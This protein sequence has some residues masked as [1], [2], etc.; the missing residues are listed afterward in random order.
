MKKLFTLIELLVVIAI[1]AILASMLLP[2]LNKARE[3]AKTIKCAGNMKSLSTMWLM[4]M[5]NNNDNLLSYD[6]DTIRNPNAGS[7]TSNDG[8]PYQ[9]RDELN[10]PD[11]PPGYWGIIPT[12]Y[13]KNSIL[14][15]PSNTQKNGRLLY[16]LEPHYGMPRYFIGGDNYSP[17]TAI[18]DKVV[19]IKNP[20]AK[21]AFG[22][23]EGLSSGYAGSLFITN[24]QMNGGRGFAT[25]RHGGVGNMIF[26]DGHVA[27][28][29][30]AEAKKP[31][32]DYL[33]A[34]SPLWGGSK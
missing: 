19:K 20:S 26:C 21:C 17:S 24:N 22:D 3:K 8:W 13:R 16:Q 25:I 33:F 14:R 9:M 11:M 1:I 15:C 23:V 29:S 30:T 5:G 10:M 4:Y 7:V 31:Y 6:C 34:R 18:F 12:Q 32:P 28:R 2:A 27:K